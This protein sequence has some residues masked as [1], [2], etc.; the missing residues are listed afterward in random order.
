MRAGTGKIFA[1]ALLGCDP[2]GPAASVDGSMPRRDAGEVIRPDAQAPAHDASWWSP[3]ESEEPPPGPGSG[4]TVGQWERIDVPVEYEDCGAQTMLVDPVRPSDFYALVCTPDGVAVLKSTDY[5]QSFTR[6]NETAWE[7]NPTGGAIDPN[8]C[9]DPETPPTL[10]STAFGGNLGLWRSTDGGVTW[11]Q[12]IGSAEGNALAPCSEYWPPDFYGVTVLPDD[13]PDHILVTFHAGGFGCEG[14]DGGFGE[15]HDGGATWTLHRGPTPFGS[16][17]YAV[18]IDPWTWLVMAEEELL[19][20][21]TSAGR[22]DGS[23]SPG[24]WELVSDVGHTHGSFQAFVGPEAIY[25]PGR[26]GIIRS[27]NSGETWTNVYDG[28][29]YMDSVIGTERHLYANA[30]YEPSL[31]RATR[32][33]GTDWEEY[34]ER[35]EGMS[36]G[37]APHG[38]AASFDGEHWVIL[39]ANDDAGI[40][41]YVEP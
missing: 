9:R 23:P 11:E 12:R 22:A 32:A 20:R 7:H 13:P 8:R 24:A 4:G 21:T 37:P 33:D 19:Y 2:S 36:L 10:Y 15:S 27:T 41:R 5:G 1:I 26:G 16:S 39:T 25:A 34:A 6:I 30:F 3:C 17:H 18:A 35:P 28:A 40:W 29:S 38:A 31:R 14:A